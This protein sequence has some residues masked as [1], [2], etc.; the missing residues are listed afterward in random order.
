[1]YKRFAYMRSVFAALCTI[2]MCITASAVW[3]Q[4]TFEDVDLNGA[5][6]LLFSVRMQNGNRSRKNLYLAELDPHAQ[7]EYAA[8]NE[9]RLLTCFPQKLETLQNGKFLQIR[10]ADGVFI[11][12][13]NTQTLSCVSPICSLYPS[14]ALHARVRD[15]LVETA[16]SPAVS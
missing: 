8:L 15:N 9:P 1:M 2:L 14:P 12:G 4:I 13:L 6:G 5:D 10:N 3:A 7:N 16:V 11:Y